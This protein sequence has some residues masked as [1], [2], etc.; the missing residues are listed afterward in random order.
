MMD[1]REGVNTCNQISQRYND[2]LKLNEGMQTL[3]EPGV[4][5]IAVQLEL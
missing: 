5:R 2:K 1:W 3:V 4:K